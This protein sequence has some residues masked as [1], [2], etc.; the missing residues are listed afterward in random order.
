MKKKLFFIGFIL[1]SLFTQ[2]QLPPFQWVRKLEGTDGKS[3]AIDAAGNVYCIGQFT[4]TP[5]FDPGP[6]TVILDGSAGTAGYITKYTAGGN[7]VWAKQLPTA[8][9][10]EDIE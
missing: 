9:L 5:D 7:F 2:A 1:I 10:P 8:A 3:I 4:G 6:G